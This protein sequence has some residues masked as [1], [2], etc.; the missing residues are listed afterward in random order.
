MTARK[1]TVERFED[2][3]DHS[4]RV[5]VDPGIPAHSFS[6]SE[7]EAHALLEALAVALGGSV[8]T[9]AVGLLSGH[10]HLASSRVVGP[11]KVVDG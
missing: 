6:L 8:E 3:F 4:Q 5:R 7:A 11:W 10:R 1:I 9:D 2:Y